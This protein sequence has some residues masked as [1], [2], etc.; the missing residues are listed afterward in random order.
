MGA[1]PMLGAGGAA[2]NARGLAVATTP[3]RRR[4]LGV[5]ALQERVLGDLL[6]DGAGQLHVRHLQ[7]ADRL[8]QL[9]REDE[10]LLLS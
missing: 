1:A 6:V 8:L 4:G 2:P 10:A 7:Q 3:R 5:A 9:R